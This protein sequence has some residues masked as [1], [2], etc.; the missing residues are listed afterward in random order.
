M[1][2]GSKVCPVWNSFTD[3]AVL[4]N[5][6]LKE[7]LNFSGK[8]GCVQCIIGSVIIVIHAPA[9]STTQTL[10]EFFT[11]CSG[12]VFIVYG[13]I[14]FLVVMWLMFYMGPRYG[15]RYVSISVHKFCLLLPLLQGWLL[16]PRQ[17]MVYIG[18]CSLVGSFLVLAAQGMWSKQSM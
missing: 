2:I 17:P 5:V 13:G 6:F 9:T 7:K 3:S 14:A 8:I 18:V 11:L 12:Y 16:I 1:S 4:S 10:A 15:H